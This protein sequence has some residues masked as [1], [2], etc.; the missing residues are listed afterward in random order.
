MSIGKQFCDCRFFLTRKQA[1]F[2]TFLT[3]FFQEELALIKL[4]KTLTNQLKIDGEA[5]RNGSDVHCMTRWQRSR[6]PCLT[7]S[8]LVYTLYKGTWK[9]TKWSAAGLSDSG[10]SAVFPEIVTDNRKF[11]PLSNK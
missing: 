5:G 6:R 10:N 2:R 9:S 11:L 4:I 1:L 7:A 8:G 3:L